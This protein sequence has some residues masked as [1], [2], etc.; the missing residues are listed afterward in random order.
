[1]I[2]RNSPSDTA[3]ALVTAYCIEPSW[4]SNPAAEASV[5]QV[6][7]AAL[8]HDRHR[9]SGRVHVR[10]HVDFPHALD[11]VVGDLEAALGHVAGVGHEHIECAVGCDR[12]GHHCLDGLLISDIEPDGRAANPIRHDLRASLIAV[13][14]D[15]R[16]RPFCGEALHERLPDSTRPTGDDSDFACKLHGPAA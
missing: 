6:A 5:E 7:A 1:M 9:S 3:A 4:V 12:V 14:H 8:D 16:P 13:N 11:L 15:Q 10:H 2:D